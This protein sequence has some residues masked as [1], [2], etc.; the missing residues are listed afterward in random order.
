[1]NKE[2]KNK[3]FNIPDNILA[4]IKYAIANISG[5][6]TNRAN[7]LVTDRQ[8][9]YGQLKRML[10]DMKY[11]DKSVD[12]DRYNMYGGKDM[13]QWGWSI[14]NSNRTQEKNKKTMT[15]T[16][17]NITGNL[18]TRNPFLK[19]HSK[20]DNFKIPT[21]P[22]KSNSDKTSVSPLLTGKLFEEIIKIKKLMK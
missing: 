21:N 22:I 5:V 10:H 20:H 6:D 8:V 1:M 3:S 12:L 19:S 9:S 11:I 14:L 17:N 13:E 16:A 18:G 2:L 7:K 15:K 4:N